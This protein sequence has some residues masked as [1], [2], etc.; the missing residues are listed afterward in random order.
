MLFVTHSTCY[1]VAK[2]VTESSRFKILIKKTVAI[3][4][5]YCTCMLIETHAAFALCSLT[6]M[7]NLIVDRGQSNT[8]F[9]I[10]P[11]VISGVTGNS[12]ARKYCSGGKFS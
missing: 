9:I 11:D 8:V 5:I 10:S 2:L 6:A 12:A 3:V 4:T 1:V 7:D